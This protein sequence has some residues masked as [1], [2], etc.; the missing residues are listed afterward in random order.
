V[1]VADSLVAEV[2]SALRAG[3]TRRETPQVIVGAA[4]ELGP[5]ERLSS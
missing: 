1:V 2:R 5:A 4:T 3:A